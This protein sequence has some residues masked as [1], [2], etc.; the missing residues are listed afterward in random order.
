MKKSKIFAALAL[1]ACMALGTFSFVACSPKSGNNGG[2]NNGSGIT[3]T[4][5]PQIDEIYQLYVASATASGEEP[6]SYEEWYADLL[7]NAKGA[8]GDNGDKGDKGDNGADGNTWLVG[9]TAPTA[10]QGKDGDLYLDYSTWNVYHKESGAWVLLGNIKGEKGDKGDKGDNGDSGSQGGEVGETVVKD[11]GSVTI[12]SN[13]TQDLDFSGVEIGTY[14]L[15]AE[16]TGEAADGVLSSITSNYNCDMYS[17][18]IGGYRSVICFSETTTTVQLTNSTSDDLT[19]NVKL[20]EF[21]TP[22]IKLGEEIELP[23]IHNSN[24]F[25]P[26]LLDSSIVADGTTQYKISISNNKGSMAPIIRNQDNSITIATIS[27]KDKDADTG[28]YTKEITIEGGTTAIGFR[29]PNTR[30]NRNI[31]VKIEAVG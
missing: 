14:Y 13:G 2:G 4:R 21:V 27:S 8:K 7:A 12:S 26:I 25:V 23:C 29:N 6:M 3:D 16:T 24:G 1:S 9:T 17:P 19:A 10:E 11:F 5:D 20:V 30:T 22:T 31:V 15:V 18:L 28:I